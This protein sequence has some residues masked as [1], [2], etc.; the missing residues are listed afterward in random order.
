MTINWYLL[1]FLAPAVCASMPVTTYSTFQSLRTVGGRFN[2]LC[3]VT[4]ALVYDS[5]SDRL[6]LEFIVMKKHP[7]RGLAWW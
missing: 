6:L 3:W 7:V 2:N 1:I 4:V 5:A